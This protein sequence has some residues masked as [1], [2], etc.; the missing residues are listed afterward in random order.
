MLTKYLN[1]KNDVAFRHI[2]GEEKHKDILASMLNAVLKKQLHKP[3]VNVELRPTI[4][5]PVRHERKGNIIDV[6]C[7]DQDGCHYLVEMQLGA[8][9]DFQKRAEFYVSKMYSNNLGKG[10]DYRTLKKVIFLAFV[11]YVIFPKKKSYKSVHITT[12]E[13]TK[14]RVSDTFTYV[15]VELPKFRKA[16]KQDPSKLSLEE[17]FYF[18]LDNATELEDKDINR[19]VGKDKVIAKA[20]DALD[21]YGWKKEE[22]ELYESIEKD[23]R[24]YRAGI[25][26]AENKAKKEGIE[27]GE[28]RGIEKG[29]KKGIE[30]RNSEMAK[31]LLQSGELPLERIST[32]TNIPVEQLKKMKKSTH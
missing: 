7:K 20:F 26:F 24:D 8:H 22:V 2:F 3:I 6:H 31:S 16:G 32:L 28:K 21:R 19:V 27:E 1:P 5:S 18:F 11:D 4:Q 17:K 23:K 29:M 10:E 12:D 9:Q 30:A 13:E 15:Y 14:K 25:S